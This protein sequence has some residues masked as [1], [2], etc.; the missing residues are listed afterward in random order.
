MDYRIKDAINETIIFQKK[1]KIVCIVAPF[2]IL[3]SVL[4]MKKIMHFNKFGIK[5]ILVVAI[6]L[7]VSSAYKYYQTHKSI[8]LLENPK[9]VE[10][11]GLLT[12]VKRGKNTGYTIEN[13]D[14]EY[15]TGKIDIDQY[16]GKFVRITA[17]EQSNIFLIV[18]EI[19]ETIKVD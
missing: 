2:I 9:I 12:S 1:M 5:E 13:S 6:I 16:V 17:E 11:E 3:L 14:I 8:Q 7:C 10:L 4:A 18:E 15:F 19:D